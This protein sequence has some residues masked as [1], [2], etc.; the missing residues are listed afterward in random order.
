MAKLPSIGESNWGTT[1][2]T[3]L[4]QAHT[5]GT[6]GTDA[7]NN[8]KIKPNLTDAIDGS[9]VGIN[10]PNPA[11]ILDIKGNS[12]KLLTGTISWKLGENFVTGI[13]TKFT[14]E[15][16]AKNWVQFY[17]QGSEKAY[18]SAIVLSDP[19]DDFNF[20]IEE[21]TWQIDSHPGV[22]TIGRKTENLVRLADDGSD[23]DLAFKGDSIIFARQSSKVAGQEQN[24]NEV[25]GAIIAYDRLIR[26]QGPS[27]NDASLYTPYVDLVS[28]DGYDNTK[29]RAG[30]ARIALLNDKDLITPGF[31]VFQLN[32]VPGTGKDY[33][34]LFSVNKTVATF[35]VDVHA[36]AF[37]TAS[38]QNLKKEIITIPNALDSILKLR[39]VSYKW[40]DESKDTSLQLGVIAQEVEKVYPELVKEN[41]NGDKAVNYQG[42]IGPLIEAVK[43]L[44]SENEKLQKRISDL[45]SKVNN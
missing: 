40:K 18:A 36:P 44:K 38:D 4:G 32:R 34:S 26:F 23:T 25:K 6:P 41:Q 17:E 28:T 14:T 19:T 11:F 33:I 35:G 12:S 43:D 10:K 15:L 45:E 37:V 2:N 13:G 29:S 30:W 20:F 16:K 39:G 42:L 21:L 8:G 24:Y 7:A 22:L 1:L 3:F 31:E 5:V 9:Y 27:H